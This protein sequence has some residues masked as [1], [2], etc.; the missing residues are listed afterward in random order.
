MKQAADRFVAYTGFAR[1]EQVVAAA[2]STVAS[3]PELARI[4]ATH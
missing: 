4:V 2:D 1:R 3:F